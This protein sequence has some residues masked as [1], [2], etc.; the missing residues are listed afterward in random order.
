MP[1]STSIPAKYYSLISPNPSFD[2]IKTIMNLDPNILIFCPLE[3]ASIYF[4]FSVLSQNDIQTRPKIVPY[5]QH[6]IY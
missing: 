2:V 6:Q 4:N 1:E 3:V 5:Y